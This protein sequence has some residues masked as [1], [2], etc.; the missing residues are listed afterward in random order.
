MIYILNELMEMF[1]DW[2]LGTIAGILLACLVL[3]I[4]GL[5]AWRVFVAIDSWFLAERAGK[6]RIS[7]KEFNLAHAV[8]GLFLVVDDEYIVYVEVDG[9]KGS[10]MIDK[11]RY[12]KLSQDEW[13]DVSYSVGRI[14]GW[15][16]IKTL[17]QSTVTV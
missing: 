10:I 12:S 2:P 15:A 13:V 17:S 11:A 4:I 7:K 8:T 9:R 5:V 3:V 6:G 14:S 1:Q 16:H